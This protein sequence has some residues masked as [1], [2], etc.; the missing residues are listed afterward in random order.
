MFYISSIGHSASLWLSTALSSHPKIICWHGNRSIPP[1]DSGTNDLSEDEFVKGLLACEQNWKMGKKVFGSCHG[2]HGVKLLNYVNKYKGTFLAITR[3]P[4]NKI[5]SYTSQ[6]LEI[7]DRRNVYSNYKF[8]VVKFYNEYSDEINANF[9]IVFEKKKEKRTS[10]KFLIDKLKDFG[11]YSSLKKTHKYLITNKK[12]IIPKIEDQTR[13]TKVTNISIKKLIKIFGIDY[14]TNKI[15]SSF[16]NST[17]M[18]FD[19]DEEIYNKTGSKAFISMEKMTTSSTYF[20]NYIFKK[21]MNERADKKYLKK[22]FMI[23]KSNRHTYKKISTSDIFKNWPKSY[24]NYF[25]TKYEK[26]KIK[27]LYNDMNYQIEKII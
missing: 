19:Y 24:K 14:I 5:H 4:I 18:I 22:I 8:D 2:F 7:S 10:R 1:Y 3:N 25:S 21:I 20:N 26:N 12:K 15:I 13:E 6:Y 27:K 23:K 17:D 16:L 9:K 11:I